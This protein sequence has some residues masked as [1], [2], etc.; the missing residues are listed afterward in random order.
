MNLT[1]SKMMIFSQT[2]CFA[3]NSAETVRFQKI[4]TGGN[5]V[6]FRYVR[7]L[8][9]SNVVALKFENLLVDKNKLL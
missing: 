5:Q 8:L 7:Q 9:L 3:R 1:F 4:S 6:I 2:R